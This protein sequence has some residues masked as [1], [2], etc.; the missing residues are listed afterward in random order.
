MKRIRKC[1]AFLAA[2]AALLTFMSVAVF[3]AETDPLDLSLVF[4]PE[5]QLVVY[6]D[7]EWSGELSGVYGC[8]ESVSLA[9]PAVAG[10]QFA[11]WQADGSVVSYN[12]PLKLTVNANTTLY[13]VYA[14]A[15]PA[16]QPA[17]GFTSI[18]RS[19]DGKSIVLQAIASGET[20]GIV[21]STTATGNALTIGGAGVSNAAAVKLT[22]AATEVPESVLDDN[23]CY[24]LQLTPETN[25]AVYHVRAYVTVDGNTTYGDVK[26]VKLSDLESGVS[27]IAGLNGF[28]PENNLDDMLSA[29]RMNTVTFE[30]NGGVGATITQAFVSGQSVTLRANT[31]TRSGYA[32]NGWSTNKNGGGTTYTDGQSVTLT[33]NT[34]LYAQW[35]SNGGG[36][37]G[38]YTPSGGGN[39]GNTGTITYPPTISNVANGRVTL[40]PTSPKFGDKVTIAATPDAGYEVDTVTVTDANGNRVSVTKVNDTTYTFTQPNSKVKIDV[41]FKPIQGAAMTGVFAPYSDLDAN[42]WY[43]DGVRY[44]LEHGIM[45]GYGD[46][47]FGPNDTTSRAMIAQILY[48]MEGKPAYSGM[49]DFTDVNANDWYAAAIRWASAEGIVGG[50]GNGKFGPNDELTREQL[51]TILYRYAKYKG[52]NVSAQASLAAYNDA[53]SVSDWATEAMQW[54]VGSRLISGKTTTTLN[55]QDKATRAE[56]ATIIMRYCENIASK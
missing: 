24:S 16:A 27:L 4:S 12:D 52:V 31:F 54:A 49:S 29:L 5:A 53:A 34:T 44:V 43:A 14:A 33:A 42:E 20:A 3:A 17:A 41:T 19:A 47:K 48:N 28:D 56:I 46:G 6:V 45:S 38:S 10:K 2:L 22:G 39:G 35:K 50:Y 9:A 23:N 51:V 37:P 26:D 55:P 1:V 13:A 32:F 40:S 30:P 18:T 36:N 7:G 11:Y 15:K 25:D 21:Y 8:G